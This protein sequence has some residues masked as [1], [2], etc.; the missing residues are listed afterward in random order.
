MS[1]ADSSSQLAAEMSVSERE[2]FDLES[3]RAMNDRQQQAL[4]L[5]LRRE[6]VKRHSI[7]PLVVAVVA[8]VVALAGNAVVAIIQGEANRELERRKL[9]AQL[10]AKAVDVNDHEAAARNLAFLISTGLVEDREG[11]IASLV[12]E[13]KRIPI[14][15]V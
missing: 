12:K 2:R 11:R 5:E 14:Q 3:R 4:E 13:P 9:E 6:E 7:M 8:G 15:N 1:D 10:I